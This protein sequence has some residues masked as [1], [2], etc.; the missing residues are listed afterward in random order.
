MKSTE[1]IERFLNTKSILNILDNDFIIKFK[2]HDELGPANI[3]VVEMFINT[4]EEELRG[5]GHPSPKLSIEELRNKLYKKYNFDPAWWQ[6]SI[7]PNK[8]LKPL[9]G[10]NH[11]RHI[12]LFV[13]DKNGIHILTET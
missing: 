5:S 8:I 7:I 3:L 10:K 2:V 11:Y 6:V 1:V 13:V 4:T 9:V 12:I